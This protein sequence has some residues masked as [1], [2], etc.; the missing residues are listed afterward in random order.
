MYINTFVNLNLNSAINSKN[1]LKM[2]KNY[3]PNFN[4]PKRKK[5]K[6]NL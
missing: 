4:L 5:N 1:G 3:S 6:L 2:A